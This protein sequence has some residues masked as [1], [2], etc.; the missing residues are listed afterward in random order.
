MSSQDYTLKRFPWRNKTTPWADLVNH[1]YKGSGTETDPYVV[2]W[3][4]DDAENP[5]TFKPRY[6]WNI[7]ILGELQR[8]PRAFSV[9][10]A[11]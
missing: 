2:V 1:E 5:L 3:L 9:R 10:R 8:P 11:G 4:P 6:K 7:T